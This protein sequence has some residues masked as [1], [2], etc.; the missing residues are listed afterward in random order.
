[1]KNWTENNWSPKKAQT[2]KKNGQWPIWASVLCIV[3]LVV[4]VNWL[5]TEW[6]T[7]KIT[8]TLFT[9]TVWT[10]TAITC[11]TTGLTIYWDVSSRTA[12]FAF[13]LSH[14]VLIETSWKLEICSLRFECLDV[15]LFRKTPAHCTLWGDSGWRT[16][17][18]TPRK[19]CELNFNRLQ[20]DP[21]DFP[22]F[23]IKIDS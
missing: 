3:P 23:V 16:W 17:A 1:M 7:I 10:C 21:S 6:M 22:S 13:R 4:W 8:T 18:F 2:K 9:L 15:S 20:P 11:C 14:F 12:F 5:S 19:V